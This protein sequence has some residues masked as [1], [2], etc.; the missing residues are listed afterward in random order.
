MKIDFN[1][2][3]SGALGMP[4][5]THVSDT[6]IINSMP[7]A[8]I[9][10]AV[11][12]FELGSNYYN[13]DVSEGT[14]KYLSLVNTLNFESSDVP[15]LK[16]AFL[17]DNF[18]S[19]TFTNDYG[20]SF[21]QG[22][23]DTLA[24]GAAEIMQITGSETA[25]QGFK[26]ITNL[27][28]SMGDS[29]KEG[30]MKNILNMAARGGNALI[31]FGG[32][33]KTNLQNS[34]TQGGQFA[35]GL[36]NSLNKAAA[37]QRLD[38]PQIWRN[39]GFTP[40]YT[41][42][43]RLYNPKPGST[44]STEKYIIGPLAFLLCLAVPRTTDGKWYNWPLFHKVKAT[45][46]YNLDS[47]VITNIT[48]IKGGDQQQ[49]SYRQ[50]MGIVDVRIDFASLFSTMMAEENATSETSNRPTVSKYLNALRSEGKEFFRRSS[51]ISH[52][53]HLSTISSLPGRSNQTSNVNNVRIEPSTTSPLGSNGVEIL[54]DVKNL[55]KAVE[56]PAAG[57]ISR[58]NATKKNVED[59]L[60]DQ[61]PVTDADRVLAIGSRLLG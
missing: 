30:V 42:T 40:S 44:T 11:P 49:I 28:E 39:S 36:L 32:E 48:I 9:T 17:A 29:S 8:E 3:P 19:D 41:M 13:L 56:A 2:Y 27:V 24:R 53:N 31:D 37:A 59:N 10:P 16:V 26:K 54:E 51:M 34:A 25:A 33:L 20:E 23:T 60:A 18:P 58:I 50:S 55:K 6:M 14:E 46:I 35:A 15:P 22:T 7:I 61:S 57:S 47:A 1:E 4:P 38:F 12:T 52:G 43:V 5:K 21:L 45:G